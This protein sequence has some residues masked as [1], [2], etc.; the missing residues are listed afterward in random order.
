MEHPHLNLLTRL[1]NNMKYLL[2]SN[3]YTQETLKEFTRRYNGIGKKIITKLQEKNPIF[4]KKVTFYKT[5]ETKDAYLLF[6]DKQKSFVIQMDP[7][8]ET[9]IFFNDDFHIEIGSWSKNLEHDFF[10]IICKLQKE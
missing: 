10:N 3:R 4:F 2:A 6:V 5:R 8:C 7:E 1:M 9:I